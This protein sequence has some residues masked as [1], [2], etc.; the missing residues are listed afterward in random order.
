MHAPSQGSDNNNDTHYYMKKFLTCRQVIACLM[1]LLG[2]TAWAVSYSDSNDNLAMP[3]KATTLSGDDLASDT[4]WY[5]I[6]VEG[7]KYWAVGD[8]Q[9]TCAAPSGSFSDANYFCFVGNNKEGFHI[10]NRQ[11]GASYVIC[12]ASAISHEPLVPVLKSKAPVPSTLKVST[13]GGGYNFYYPGNTSACVND[14]H[15]DGVLTLWTNAAASASSGCRMYVEAVDADQLQPM[16]ESG[17]PFRCTRIIDGK[18]ASYTKWYTMDIRSG[19]MLQATADAILCAPSDSLTRDRLWCFTGSKAEGFTIY[20]YAYGTRYAACAK[21]A[22]NAT[23]VLMSQLGSTEGGATAFGL[24]QNSHGGINFH[25]PQTANS[26]W[27]DFGNNGFIALWNDNNAPYDG[28]SNIIFS[29]AD[30]SKLPAEPVA[31]SSAWDPVSGD[32]VYLCMSDGSVNAFPKEYIL[33]Q[34]SNS[35]QVSILTKSGH[36]YTFARADVDSLTEKAPAQLPQIVSFKFNNKFNDMLMMDALGEFTDSAHI[37][38]NV[39]SIGKRLVASIKTS[40]EGAEVYVGDSL[41]DS[42]VTSRRFEHP[43]TY[44]VALPGWR[45][46]RRNSATGE[47][48]MHPFGNDYQVTV[49]YLCDN[50]TNYIGVPVINITTNDGTMISSK[51]RYWD[52]KISIDGAGFLPDL[53]ETAMKIKGRG[54]SSWAGEWGKSPYRIKFP[55]KQKPLGMKAGKNW[56]LIANAIR[57]SM[58]TNVI[59]SR[60]AEMVGA[61]AANHFLPVELYINGNYRGSYTL[62]EKVGISNNSIDLANDSNAVLLELDSYY[63]ETYKF[64]TTYYNLPVNVKHP[65]FASDP[66]NLTLSVVSRHFN[67]L[68]NGVRHMKPIE[69][70]ADPVY[71]ARFLMVNELMNNQELYH[72]KSTFLYHENILS[73]S[74]RYIFGPVW[75]CDWAFGYQSSSSY[76]IRD[77]ETDYFS[78]TSGSSGGRGFLRDLRY[79]GGEELNKQYYRVWTDFM[80]NHLEDLMEYLDD[81]YAVAAKSFEHDN[82]LWA[83]GGSKE[84][85]EITERSKAWIRKRCNYI[86][87]YLSYQLGYAEKDYLKPDVPDAIDIVRS[88]TPVAKPSTGVYDL[89]GRRV[90]DTL[91]GLPSGIYI[92][93]GRKVVKR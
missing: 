73:D 12:C 78:G 25:Y 48:G 85:A 90:G 47:Y 80:Q 91:D 70:Y 79:N 19:K 6:R 68:V 86:Y 40:V 13:N 16:Q 32:I 51:S 67:S 63:D 69:Q 53:P 76:F 88:D 2:Q 11:L 93:N 18:F 66:T 4:Q 56:N 22:D 23:R 39:G 35:S 34:T 58:T 8:G 37:A 31:D 1:V 71:L 21:S 65:D 26:C 77:V 28:G 74:S 43:V 27:N 64:K 10:Y 83:K 61:A 59:G 9:V 54:N 52:A 46:L 15:S 17:V 75:D 3:F 5:K 41:Q 20:N 45:M 72:P 82:S 38:V 24:S 81:Y 14:L 44:T 84:Y 33:T 60:V 36:K 29:E 92:Q 55:T 87:N 7:G 89:W 30:L 42:K 57:E 49:N 62:T 50:P